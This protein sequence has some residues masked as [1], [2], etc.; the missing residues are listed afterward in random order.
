MLLARKLFE[1]LDNKGLDEVFT[2]ISKSEID[3]ISKSGDFDFHSTAL[4]R[5]IRAKKAATIIKSVLS[6]EFRRLFD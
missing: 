5:I 3:F 4:S 6:N 1:R 2:S